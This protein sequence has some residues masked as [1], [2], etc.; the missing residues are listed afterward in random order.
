MHGK[1]ERGG[2]SQR[3][4]LCPDGRRH[5]TE[6]RTGATRATRGGR[7][8]LMMSILHGQLEMR[9]SCESDCLALRPVMR[10]VEVGG[11]EN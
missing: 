7:G 10:L 5:A 8:A 3:S 2:V 1:V 6:S 4:E 9:A 11:D